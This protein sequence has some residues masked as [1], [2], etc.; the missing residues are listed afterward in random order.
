MS[1]LSVF[2][3]KC[4]VRLYEANYLFGNHKAMP[5]WM[6][7][8]EYQE[9]V[10]EGDPKRF[11]GGIW[12]DLQIWKQG[13]WG[14]VHNGKCQ[15]SAFS[16]RGFRLRVVF[17]WDFTSRAALFTEW[18]STTESEW[19]SNFTV[20]LYWCASLSI[21]AF[22]TSDRRLMLCCPSGPSSGCTRTMFVQ[23]TN[24]FEVSLF[25]ERCVKFFGLTFYGCRWALR[26]RWIEL[27]L[28]LAQVNWIR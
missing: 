26:F 22:I 3:S 5:N 25:G 28:V 23:C 27:K 1:R 7:Y 15:N 11:S 18:A 2:A 20:A 21:G 13:K 10:R 9:K 17:F 4:S 6:L 14:S 16:K 8:D 24:L 19:N 12:L